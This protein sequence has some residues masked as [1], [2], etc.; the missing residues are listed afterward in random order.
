[1]PGYFYPMPDPR[2]RQ[3]N[4]WGVA[5]LVLGIGGLTVLFFL[6]VPSILAVVF[7][8][9]GRRAAANG[10]ADNPGVALAGLIMGYLGVAGWSLIGMLALIGLFAAAADPY[11]LT[12]PVQLA[13]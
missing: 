8:H 1:M 13:L 11:S 3:K 12:A 5:S 9:I 6:V 2:A 10:E 7:G 4:G